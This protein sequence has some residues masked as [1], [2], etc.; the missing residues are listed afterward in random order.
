METVSFPKQFVPTNTGHFFFLT[1]S[2]EFKDRHLQLSFSE[3]RPHHSSKLTFLTLV[4]KNLDSCHISSVCVNSK[5]TGWPL[6]SSK[7]CTHLEIALE[8]VTAKW[9]WWPTGLLVFSEPESEGPGCTRLPAAGV[10]SLAFWV[11]YTDLPVLFHG[12]CSLWHTD[13]CVPWS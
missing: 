5:I 11:S 8:E 13:V 12:I 6:K 2:A 3:P 9:L 7:V 1:D 4:C 10:A